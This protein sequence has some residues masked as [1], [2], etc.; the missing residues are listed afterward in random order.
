MSITLTRRSISPEHFVAGEQHTWPI[1][2]VAVSNDAAIPSEIFVYHVG[3]ADVVTSQDPYPGDLFE[4]VASVHQLNTIP[5]NDPETP[6]VDSQNPFYRT[7]KLFFHCLTL[8][9]A[10][11]LWTNVQADVKDLIENFEAAQNLMDDEAVTV[12]SEVVL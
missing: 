12:E 8:K 5:V 11:K 6:G 2:I 3:A 4:C 10:D 1:E 9:D 7:A